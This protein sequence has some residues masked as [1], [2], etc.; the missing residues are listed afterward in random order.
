MWSYTI[1]S[2]FKTGLSTSPSVSRVRSSVRFADDQIPLNINR[3]TPPGLGQSSTAANRDRSDSQ[4]FSESDESERASLPR[5]Q[6]QL[7][8]MIKD[9]RRKSGS[10]DLGASQ[11]E[12]EKTLAARRK[13]D[14]LLQM[15]REAAAA[16]VPTSRSRRPSTDEN[17]RYRSPS[18]GAT[19]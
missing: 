19:F 12:S 8:M 14:E 17:T 16:I 6:S 2:A 11:P 18:P 15:G 13:R 10:Q 7:S 3:N 5:V 1:A 4:V 9:K